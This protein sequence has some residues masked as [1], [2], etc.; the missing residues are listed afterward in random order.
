MDRTFNEGLAGA[1]LSLAL[2][3]AGNVARAPVPGLHP[4]L[5]FAA[6]VGLV[7]LA[8]RQPPSELANDYETRPTTRR[9]ISFRQ[10]N[11]LV[12]VLT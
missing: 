7:R 8:G 11:G 9:S 4:G 12:G 6:G 10:R 2:A 3:V 5:T 1:T